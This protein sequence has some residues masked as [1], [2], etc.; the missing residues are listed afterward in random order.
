MTDIKDEA[1]KDACQASDM[2]QQ[3]Q[4]PSKDPT[5]DG[6]PSAIGST[7]NS[8]HDPP[9]EK[10]HTT[11][12][13]VNGVVCSVKKGAVGYEDIVA[14]AGVDPTKTYDITFD[15]G[16]RGSEKGMLVPHGPHTHIGD[17]EVFTVVEHVVKTLIIVNG[18]PKEV[19]GD[20]ISFEQVVMLAFGET[21]SACYT[22][23][24]EFGPEGVEHGAME[25]GQVVKIKDKEVFDVSNTYKS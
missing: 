5:R 12:I 20:T 1:R 24:Y 2:R 8:P 14:I 15:H 23:V 3:A 25:P 17:G 6:N 11:S 21:T 13:I 4:L 22:V 19:V 7:V 10:A 18:S 16:P 9:G